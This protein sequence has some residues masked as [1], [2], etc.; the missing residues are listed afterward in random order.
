MFRIF[1]LFKDDTKLKEILISKSVTSI[2][3][4]AFSSCTNI[5]KVTYEGS[6][7][8]WKNV[9]ISDG[10]ERLTKVNIEFN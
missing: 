1:G 6:K 4:N 3:K 8:D 2:G 7:S 9:K 10:N 5:E